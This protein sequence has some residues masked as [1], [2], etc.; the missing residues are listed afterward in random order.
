[1]KNYGC[2][3]NAYPILGECSINAIA[4]KYLHYL[5]DHRELQEGRD[6][7]PM[8]VNLKAV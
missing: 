6:G 5:A 1:M 2:L 3:V 8:A 7:R 4:L